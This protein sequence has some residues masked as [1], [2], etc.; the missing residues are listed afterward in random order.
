MYFLAEILH[1]IDRSSTTSK[2]KIFRLAAAPIKI[3]Q[4]PYVIFRTKSQSEENSGFQSLLS[5]M[6][7]NIFICYGQK[8]MI[9][10]LISGLLTARMKIN[11]IPWSVFL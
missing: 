10:V 7:R 3:H 11:Q 9:K 2:C 8:E 5:V 4:I 1:A 6:R